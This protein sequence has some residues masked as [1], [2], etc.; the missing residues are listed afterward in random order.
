M[1]NTKM[2]QKEEC[3]NRSSDER[4]Y[5]RQNVSIWPITDSMQLRAIEGANLTQN[6]IN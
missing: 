6:L 1:A 3:L 5:A 4:N 2:I